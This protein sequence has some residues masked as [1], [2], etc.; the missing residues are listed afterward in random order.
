MSSLGFG[1]SALEEQRLLLLEEDQLFVSHW[2]GG[3]DGR[4]NKRFPENIAFV[5]LVP[6][7]V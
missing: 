2:E 5:I 7:G 1:A 6:G 3:S 4:D